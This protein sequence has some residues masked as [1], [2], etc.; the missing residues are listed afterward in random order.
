MNST[1]SACALLHPN[2]RVHQNGSRVEIMAHDIRGNH[3]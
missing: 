1:G 2:G 3:K